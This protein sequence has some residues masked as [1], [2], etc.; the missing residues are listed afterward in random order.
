MSRQ[1]VPLGVKLEAIERY[2]AFSA[3][4]T[5]PLDLKGK[6]LVAVSKSLGRAIELSGIPGIVQLQQQY[7]YRISRRRFRALLSI[8]LSFG[9]ILFASPNALRYSRIGLAGGML[10]SGITKAEARVRDSKA[11]ALV[12]ARIV[13]AWTTWRSSP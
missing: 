11:A 4:L 1:T 9:L 6:G 12:K 7:Y 8:R 2:V 13:V 3:C 5:G 10:E